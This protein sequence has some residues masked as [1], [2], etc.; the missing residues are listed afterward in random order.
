MLFTCRD[1][2]ST[3]QRSQGG[4]LTSSVCSVA[5]DLQA[6]SFLDSVNPCYV[7]DAMD[8]T[9]NKFAG[10]EQLDAHEFLSDFVDYIHEEWGEESKKGQEA[11]AATYKTKRKEYFPTDN[12]CMT[13]QVC[14]KCCSCGNS[15][16]AVLCSAH[17]TPAPI[18][19]HV[20]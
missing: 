17:P 7:K 14:L 11:D 18:Q 9:A 6:V 16:Y 3:L 10:L 5:R 8:E 13:V 19:L 1:F 20:A 4:C 2:M 15:R 12:F